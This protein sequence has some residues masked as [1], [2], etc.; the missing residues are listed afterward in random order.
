VAELPDVVSRG[1]L[2]G[3]GVLLL[4]GFVAIIFASGSLIIMMIGMFLVLG[5]GGL[6]LKLGLDVWKA[7]E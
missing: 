1:L 4:L 7:T 2:V 3:A 6:G 5:G